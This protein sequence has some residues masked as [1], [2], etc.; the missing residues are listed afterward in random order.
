MIAP[1]NDRVVVVTGAAR[2]IGRAATE[3][4]LERGAVVA[5]IDCDGDELAALRA[6]NRD[7]AAR[8]STHPCDIADRAAI[9]AAIAAVTALRRR[10]DVLVNNAA[11]ADE[12]PIERLSDQRLR[13]VMAVN[14][15]GALHCIQ[16]AL[17][18]LRES[19]GAAIVNVASTQGFR[20]QPN[21]L[22][23]AAT[24]A[25][26][27][28]LTHSLA[29]DLGPAGIRVNAVAPGFI[30]TRMAIQPDGQHEHQSDWF[31]DVYLRHGRLPLRRA[32]QPR[33]VAGAIV[34]LAGDDSRYITGQVI[35]VDGG[36]TC[37]Y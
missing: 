34:F 35:V 4:M 6:A 18:Q 10:I 8:L 19:S 33:E 16:A 1:L 26:L 17:P 13:S 15:E 36:L 28:S 25:A 12:T 31:R 32:G 2:G 29:V 7:Y 14:F 27:I 3:A 9:E 24:K 21:T 20:G 30:D 5:A 11:I 22:A 23:Y 37:T